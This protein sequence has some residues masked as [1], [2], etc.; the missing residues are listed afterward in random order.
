MLCQRNDAH[1]ARTADQQRGR[2][3]RIA[4][5]LATALA[6]AA[7]SI[8]L[9]S[10]AG[11]A[12]AGHVTAPVM[13]APAI[14]A[15][16]LAAPTTIYGKAPSGAAIRSGP[17]RSA[18]MVS[19]L[20]HGVP[21]TARYDRSTGWYQI[22]SGQFIDRVVVST[23]APTFRAYD[24]LVGWDEQ[25]LVEINRVRKDAGVRPVALHRGME[26]IATGWS[27]H[28]AHGKTGYKLVHQ[29]KASY[30]SLLAKNGAADWRKW[31][32]N[33]LRGPKTTTPQQ[34]IDAYMASPGH[35][36]NILDPRFNYVGVATV[37]GGDG[38]IYNTMSLLE[39][40]R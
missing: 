20:P 8:A 22:S 34:G 15:P 9:A 3:R 18:K 24:R 30:R 23:S 31:G 17:S 25:L 35:R 29:T 28:M 38:Y 7:A 11:A 40:R 2:G 26:R 12:P 10:P 1:T 14:A 16:H 21:V 33:I 32:E 4:L 13:A 19:R 5:S 39:L 37:M 36:A 27:Q 6:T